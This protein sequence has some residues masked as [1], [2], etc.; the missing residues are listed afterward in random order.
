MA[1]QGGRSSKD[2]LAQVSDQEQ[3]MGMQPLS[4]SAATSPTRKKCSRSPLR[5]RAQQNGDNAGVAGTDPDISPFL[6]KSPRGSPD[7]NLMQHMMIK[8]KEA[9]GS[10]TLRG[11]PPPH[12][13]NFISK[14]T[15]PRHWPSTPASASV[16]DRPQQFAD[17][18]W[19]RIVTNGRESND[20]THL[21]RLLAD[22]IEEFQF[23]NSGKVSLTTK[24]ILS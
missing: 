10:A 18:D 1:E 23:G 7:Q 8:K 9:E 6:F 12:S 24:Q 17:R 2:L 21:I 4:F 14:P 16:L 3:Y 19:G 15:N 5:A 20:G 11:P 22:F 13:S